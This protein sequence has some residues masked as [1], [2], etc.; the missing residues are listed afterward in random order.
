MHGHAGAVQPVA[1]PS[2]FAVVDPDDIVADHSQ[3]E[4]SEAYLQWIASFPRGSSPVS[5]ATGALCDARQDG[6]VWFLAASDGTAP[7]ER[8]CA[9]PA[10]KTLFVPIAAVTE[11]S[12]NREP[13]CPS[14]AR[15]AADTLAQQ[16]VKPAMSVD[17]QVVYNIESH[18]VATGE[19]FALGL[20]QTPRSPLKGAVADGYYVMLR[21]LPPGTHTLV[22]STRPDNA[23]LTTTYRLDVR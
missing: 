16:V 5:D 23:A 20:R 14:M 8:R 12:G 19:C 18:R 15:I 17:G 9:V 22:T 11:R 1:S 10:G 4:W 6:E 2:A 7:V 21:P 13:D 3:L